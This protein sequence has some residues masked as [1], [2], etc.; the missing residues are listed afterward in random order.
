[1]ARKIA[2]LIVILV[3]CLSSFGADDIGQRLIGALYYDGWSNISVY[4]GTG[5]ASQALYQ[6]SPLPDKASFSDWRE[7]ARAK[8]GQYPPK[9]CSFSMYY[10]Q[11]APVGYQDLPS[12][13]PFWGWR[14]DSVADIEQEI[15]LAADY[16][17][18]FFMFCLY[19]RD[20]F[21]HSDKVDETA[22]RQGYGNNAIY[23]FLKASNKSRMKFC[24]LI[25]NSH[26]IG[27]ASQLKNLVAYIADTFFN[28]P[29][30]LHIN[31]SPVIG[32]FKWGLNAAGL[33]DSYRKAGCKFICNAFT[34]NADGRMWYAGNRDDQPYGF[35]P[36]KDLSDFNSRTALRN[37]LHPCPCRMGRPCPPRFR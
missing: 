19:P 13:K 2:T 9:D 10:P 11:Y 29:S 16:G 35:S 17:I 12:R 6:A 5:S 14:R 31:G 20:C 33:D 34:K 21:R 24:I 28:E 4:G 32:L 26:G 25:E 37:F 3:C 36:Y 22:L 27:N 18:D 7:Y 8:D 1:M 30:Y 15:D 23:Q